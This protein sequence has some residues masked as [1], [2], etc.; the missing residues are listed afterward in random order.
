L[1][2]TFP[3]RRFAFIVAIGESKNAVDVLR[4]FFGLSASFIFTAFQAPGRSSVNPQRLLNIAEQAGQ[5][6]RAIADPI[7]ALSVARRNADAAAI[8][9][10]TGSTFVVGALRGWWLTNVVERAR[11]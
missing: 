3:E 10:V 11:N 6:A 1:A 9:V 2:E 7:E 4:P 8:V 5:S